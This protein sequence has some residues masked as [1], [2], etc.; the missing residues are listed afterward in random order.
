MRIGRWCF[1][2]TKNKQTNQK[3]EAKAGF[4][5]QACSVS[6]TQFFLVLSFLLVLCVCLFNIVVL[7]CL[8]L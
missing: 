5:K 7:V 3:R 4:T 1:F 6:Y 2:S 8:I